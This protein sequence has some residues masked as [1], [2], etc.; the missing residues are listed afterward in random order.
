LP[1][2][3]VTGANGFIGKAVSVELLANGINVV[4]AVRNSFTL[5]GTTVAKIS[6]IDGQTDWSEALNG[7]DCIVH[8]AARAH[9]MDD[10][11]L[12]PYAEFYKVNVE[13]TLNLARQAVEYGIKRL[14]YLSSIGVN[15]NCNTKPFL[16]IDKSN[17]VESYAVS[18]YEAENKLLTLAK[19]SSIEV[20]I[21]RPPLVYGPNAPGNFGKLVSWINKGIPMPL[22]AIY[23]KRSLVALDNLVGFIMRCVEHPKAANEIFLISDGEDVSTTE[24]VNKIGAALGKIP[25]LIPV[26]VGLIKSAAK[27]LGLEVTVNRLFGSLKIDSSKA[28]ELLGWKAVI[29]M[30]QQLQKM[31]DAF[32]NEKSI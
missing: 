25:F 18:K 21:I 15:G 30:E 31:A 28:K 4:C 22:G 3:L 32:E 20:V 9:I 27:L 26:P 11:A 1:K 29:T 2:I 16:E 17:P 24:L 12:D 19:E 13:G 6:D 14:V 5:E 10:R 23:N 8:T 7:V